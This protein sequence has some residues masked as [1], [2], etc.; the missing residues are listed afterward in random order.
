VSE[1]TI[2][3]IWFTPVNVITDMPVFAVPETADK[4]T[5]TDEAVDV[6]ESSITLK[7]MSFLIP[8]A[9][10]DAPVARERD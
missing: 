7:Y 5:S 1:A 10:I 6:T 3:V 2:G 8:L 4:V 9:M